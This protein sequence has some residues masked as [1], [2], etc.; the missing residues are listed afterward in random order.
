MY[1]KLITINLTIV[2]LVTAAYILQYYF[3]NYP[4]QFDL[5]YIVKECQLQYLPFFFAITALVS[6]LVSSLNFKKL[7]FKGKF[8]RVFPFLNSLILAFFVFI[9]FTAFIKNKKDLNALEKHYVQEAEKDIRKDQVVIRN[10]GFIVPAY[11]EKT[12]HLINSIYQK[13]GIVSKNTGCI[14][15]AMD[16][17]AQEKYNEL[18]DPYLE[19]RNGN[20]WKQRMEKE[21]DDVEKIMGPETK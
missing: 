4:V 5:W 12:V 19:K 2:L 7:S 18:T 21:I 9:S 1:K 15:D 3:I 14:I 13:Y 17:K 11:D 10:V 6:Y 8:L 20:N 16:T